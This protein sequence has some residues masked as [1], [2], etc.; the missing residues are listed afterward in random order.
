MPEKQARIFVVVV[1]FILVPN[2]QSDYIC[3]Y[4]SPFA[5]LVDPQTHVRRK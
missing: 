1:W 5:R 2:G 4:A 3:S